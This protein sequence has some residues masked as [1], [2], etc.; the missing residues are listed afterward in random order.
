MD[1]PEVRNPF[2]KIVLFPGFVPTEETIRERERL[3]EEAKKP[4][5]RTQSPPTV[6][7]PKP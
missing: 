3:I 4:Y 5:H 6:E 2:I 1:D 7:I